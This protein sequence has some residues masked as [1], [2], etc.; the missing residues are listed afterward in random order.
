VSG[1]GRDARGADAAA[2]V[3]GVPV[4]ALER[5]AEL[6]R[7]VEEHAFRY[8]VL[9]APTVADAEYDALLL[10]LRQ[11]E[12]AHPSLRTPDSPTQK[13]MG[14]P[15][16]SFLPVEHLERLMSLGN[17]FTEDEL[18]EWAGRARKEAAAGRPGKETL[19]K[20]VD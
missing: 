11:L 10:E 13:V 3:D 18:K 9:D 7:T 2:A 12:E 20:E 16:T 14:T 19:D 8:Y 15:S 4:P 6:S 5:H 17:V 1:A